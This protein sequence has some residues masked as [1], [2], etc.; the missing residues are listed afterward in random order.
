[1]VEVELQPSVDIDELRTWWKHIDQLQRGTR[2]ITPI[3]LNYSD[4]TLVIDLEALTT[5]C[6]E[7]QQYNDAKGFSPTRVNVLR[8]IEY[9]QEYESGDVITLMEIVKRLEEEYGIERAPSTISQHLSALIDDELIE[10]VGSP[11]SGVYRYTG[12]KIPDVKPK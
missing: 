2:P 5:I 8:I 10:R 6:R 3:E 9:H 4:E 11:T 12:P 7:H 1:M